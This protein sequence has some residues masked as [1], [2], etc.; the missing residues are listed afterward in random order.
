MTLKDALRRAIA[1]VFGDA[2][3]GWPRRHV[4]KLLEMGAA[5]FQELYH[6]IPQD[7]ID[8]KSPAQRS[9]AFDPVRAAEKMQ[10]LFERSLENEPA[11]DTARQ[12]HRRF[13]LPNPEAETINRL[14]RFGTPVLRQ[15]LDDVARYLGPPFPAWLYDPLGYL[16]AK[17][18]RIWEARERRFYQ[19]RHDEQ[20]ASRRQEEET[21]C[22]KR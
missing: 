16:E 5:V 22:R 13:Q 18:R 14:K 21:A 9:K 3:P 1:A 8:G 4:T 12:L 10:R 19:A 20:A 17:A 6:R 11:D 7:A 15:L 2:N